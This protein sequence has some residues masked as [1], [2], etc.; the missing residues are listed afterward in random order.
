MKERI[1][2]IVLAICMILPIVPITAFF[3]G[4]YKH[5]TKCVRLCYK[6]AVDG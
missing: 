1:L 6:G 5:C 2:S 3:R 4:K